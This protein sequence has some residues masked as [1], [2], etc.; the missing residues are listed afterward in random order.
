MTWKNKGSYKPYPPWAVRSPWV[1]K[2]CVACGTKLGGA[3]PKALVKQTM[4]FGCPPLPDE[5]P[6]VSHLHCIK[7]PLMK[8][9]RDE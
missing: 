9:K 4:C 6:S 8:G 3:V 7:N 1:E 5:K 2:V